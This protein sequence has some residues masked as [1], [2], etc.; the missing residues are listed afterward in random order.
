MS[1][2]IKFLYCLIVSSFLVGCSSAEKIIDNTLKVERRKTND[3][4]ALLDSL[5]GQ[6]PS[7]FYA[8]IST[9]FQDTNSNLRFKTSLRMVRDS[10]INL[11]FTYAKFPV[12]NAIISR[13][14]LIIV[15]KRSKCIIKEDLSYIKESF[16]ID[17]V[18]Q[19]LEEIFLGLPLDFDSKQKYFQIHL[20]YQYVISTHRKYKIKR[21]EKKDK[22]D[23]LVK[24]FID[25]DAKGL[26]AIHISSPSDSTEIFVD[27]VSRE[28][29]DGF[30]IPKL[31]G[32]DV[33]TPRNHIIINL[34]YDKF[35]INNPQPLILVIPDGYEKCQ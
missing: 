16:G 22:E 14:S 33:K 1:Q 18:Y 6:K 11:L 7:F 10:A 26:S 28:Q 8:K 12:A 32:I 5:S 9:D 31:V 29:S 27:Y 34:D 23:V 35:E 3:L 13:D 21:T 24:Y 19:N 2:S 15:N 30:N 20:P 25:K 17:F 4:V